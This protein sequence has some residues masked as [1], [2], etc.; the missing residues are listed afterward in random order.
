MSNGARP[1]R[2]ILVGVLLVSMSLL[3]ACGAGGKSLPVL[4][5]GT[6]LDQPLPTAIEH[7]TFTDATGRRVH[8]SDYAGKTIVLDDILTLCQ[9]HCPIDTA[10]FVDTAQRYA[11]TARHAGDVVFLSITVDPQRDTPAQL[12]AYR[13]LY[14][15]PRSRL[16][17]WHLLTAAPSELSELWR[18]LHVYVQRVREDG[19]QA[20]RNWRTGR[21]LTYDVDHGD[22]VYFIDAHGTERY[23]LDGQPYVRGA[24]IPATMERFMSAAGRS[25][26][27]SGDWTSTEALQVIDA[28]TAEDA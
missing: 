17:Q 7:M 19:G 14:A 10:A 13:R 12:A 1:A 21:P 8:F 22:D 18:L 23:L 2:L 24:T 20:P 5:S 3:V 15:G 26:E 27:K 6:S 28:L 9:E 11:T 16:P 25:N 4:S